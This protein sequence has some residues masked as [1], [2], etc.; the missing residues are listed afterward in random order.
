MQTTEDIL[1]SNQIFKLINT[2][3][4]SARSPLLMTLALRVWLWFE[5]KIDVSQPTELANY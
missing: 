1:S 4:R 3:K 2:L 5:R